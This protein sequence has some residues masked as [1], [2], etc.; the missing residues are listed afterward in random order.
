M[1]YFTGF[2]EPDSCLILSKS[3]QSN[4]SV[5]FFATPNDESTLLWSGPRAGI[6]GSRELFGLQNT[7]DIK[8]LKDAVEELRT[9]IF[10]D[11]HPDNSAFPAELYQKLKNNNCKPLEP[12]VTKL[13]LVKCEE[14]QELMKKSGAIAAESFKEVTIMIIVYINL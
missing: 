14:E 9:N 3:S 7:F 8:K 5:N 1:L 2:N 4:L 13:R 11:Y 12:F 10:I 6:E